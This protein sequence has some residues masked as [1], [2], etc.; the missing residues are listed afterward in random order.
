VPA[1]YNQVLTYTFRDSLPAGNPSKTIFGAYL[2]GEFQA[3]HVASLDAAS[4]SQSNTFTGGTQ[5]IQGGLVVGAPTGGSEGNGTINA[6]G[7]F[8]NGLAVGTGSGSVTSV[9]VSSANGAI[10]VSGSPVTSSG[11]IAITSNAFTSTQPGHVPASGGGVANFLRADGTWDQLP[12]SDI[13]G[14]IAS[15]QVPV[16]AVTQWQSSLSIGWS[17]ITGVP[18]FTSTVAGIAPASGG[19]TSNFLRADGS[20]ATPPA[21]GGTVSSI[22]VASGGVQSGALTVSGSP[23]TSSGTITI[24][25]N[26]FSASVAGVAPAS[27][28]GT[29]NY[30]RADG[31]WTTVPASSVTGLATSATTDATNASNITGGTLSNARINGNVYRGNLGSGNITISTSA[32]SGGSDGDIWFQY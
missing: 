1:T 6:Q 19:G 29:V 11:T 31:S 32:P 9:G 18:T 25:P 20:W 27:G 15:S 23:V 4:L 26:L 2:D 8:V 16:G 3:I 7:L 5:T 13:T 21:S 10:S 17:Q 22:G 24:T 14:T 12:F 30:L 28:G